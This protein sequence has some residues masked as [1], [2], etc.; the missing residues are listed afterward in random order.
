[1]RETTLAVTKQSTRLGIGKLMFWIASSAL[2]LLAM[3]FPSSFTSSIHIRHC[4]TTHSGRGNPYS[5]D[6]FVATKVAPRND[7]H[8]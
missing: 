7:T 3:T 5:L 8:N 1:M 6:C 4:E 2:R